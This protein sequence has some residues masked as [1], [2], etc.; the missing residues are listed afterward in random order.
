M[1]QGEGK[2]KAT[3]IPFHCYTGL[4]FNSSLWSMKPFAQCCILGFGQRKRVITLFPIV[5][6]T[7][8]HWML[9]CPL[10]GHWRNDQGRSMKTP[11]GPN[12]QKRF[13]EYQR[14]SVC[15]KT[16]AKDKNYPS[17]IHRNFFL[18]MSS[19]PAWPKEL[20]TC[21]NSS[22]EKV[23]YWK[24]K[25]ILFFPFVVNCFLAVWCRN[26]LDLKLTKHE[27]WGF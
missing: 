3:P 19:P 21:S 1:R 27:A 9:I 2:I 4:A 11:V 24:D 22:H 15:L 20:F 16:G 6:L 23:F 26:K 14:A 10:E 5:R 17:Q 18:F 25:K 12:Y 13:E 7:I 8:Q